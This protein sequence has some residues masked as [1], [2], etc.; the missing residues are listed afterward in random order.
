M[1]TSIVLAVVG[2]ALILYAVLI[3]NTLIRRKNHYLNA[4]SQ[5]DV[6]LQRRYELIPNLVEIA[7]GYLQHEQQTLID[8]TEARN[9][10]AACSKDAAADPG[11]PGVM[12]ALANAESRLTGAMG[13]LNVVIEA[14]PELQADN[15][16][17]DLH[18][19][20]TTTENRVGYAR[21]AYSDASMR[22]NTYREQ[23]PP[24]IVARLFDFRE[25]DLFVAVNDE[26][27]QRVT[28]SFDKAA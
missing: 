18:D 3:Y 17:Q 24:V 23:F 11:T 20:L 21:Q 6:Q 28:V 16:M 13:K 25:A 9:S 4:Y 7:K 8:V 12:Q 2:V 26:I 14:Y 22:Y 5:I 10:A 1:S 19:Q 15:R 27:H